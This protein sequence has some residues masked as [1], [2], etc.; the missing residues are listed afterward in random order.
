MAD[1]TTP[2]DDLIRAQIPSW[3]QLFGQDSQ[4]ECNECEP[5]TAAP[6][7]LAHIL[8]FAENGC[9][10]NE[11]LVIPDPRDNTKMLGESP[12]DILIKRAPY[13]PFLPLTC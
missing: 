2:V 7:S 1:S 10:R 8:L 13:L 4:C 6:A 9:N 5:M 12:Y 11:N 3:N